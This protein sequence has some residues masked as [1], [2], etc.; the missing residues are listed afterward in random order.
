MTCCEGNYKLFRK[1]SLGGN[2]IPV[3]PSPN[4]TPNLNTLF[5][6]PSLLP[7]QFSRAHPG[8]V[9]QQ[10]TSAIYFGSFQRCKRFCFNLPKTSDGIAMVVGGA[11]NSVYN[12]YSLLEQFRLGTI[13]LKTQTEC[14]AQLDNLT[15][16]QIHLEMKCCSFSSL[17]CL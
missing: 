17:N 4:L 8:S 5:L 13:V 10:D 16:T 6:L 3:K 15:S 7:K 14:K 2:S 1:S 11:I 12:V 9:Q